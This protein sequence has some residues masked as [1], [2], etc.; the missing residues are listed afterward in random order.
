[1]AGTFETRRSR[2]K[3]ETARRSL[4]FLASY[5]LSAAPAVGCTVCDSETGQ[6]VRAGIFGDDFVVTLAAVISPFPILLLAVGVLHAINSP[7]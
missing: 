4:L 6:Q 3:V 1:M 7:K 2:K 5:L